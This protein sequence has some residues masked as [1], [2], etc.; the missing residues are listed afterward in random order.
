VFLVGC[1]G[2]LVRRGWLCWG[3]R[4]F[5]KGGFLLSGFFGFG[6]GFGFGWEVVVGGVGG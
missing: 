2:G 6:F 4:I 1:G 3:L 5:V